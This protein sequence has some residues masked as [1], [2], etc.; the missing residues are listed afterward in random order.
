MFKHTVMDEPNKSYYMH[1]R[2][3]VAINLHTMDW[4]GEQKFYRIY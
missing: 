4:G 1:E 3:N 2:Y